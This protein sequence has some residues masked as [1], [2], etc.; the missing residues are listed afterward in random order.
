MYL[1]EIVNGLLF[2]VKGSKLKDNPVYNNIVQDIQENQP[3]AILFPI[4]RTL[5]C[6]KIVLA[7]F[8]GTVCLEDLLYGLNHHVRS[9]KGEKKEYELEK[10]GYQPLSR[11]DCKVFADTLRGDFP[12]YVTGKKE[13]ID[14]DDSYTE[15]DY[16][17]L[18]GVPVKRRDVEKQLKRW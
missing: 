11:Y 15:I 4:W 16:L 2:G 10:L 1:S 14:R 6:E 9:Y 17:V 13:A 7:Y 5:K 3:Q 12:Q 18:R 8:E